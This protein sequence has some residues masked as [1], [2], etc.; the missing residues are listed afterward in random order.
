MWLYHGTYDMFYDKIKS[1]KKLNPYVNKDTFTIMLSQ[2]INSVAGRTLRGNC[3]YLS[4]DIEAM[5]GFDRYFR[6]STSKLDTKRLFV[7]DNSVL[8]NIIATVNTPESMQYI[9][10]YIQS[11][12][13]F[14]KYVK[15]KQQYNKMYTPEFLYFGVIKLA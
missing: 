10:K 6:I 3:V 2:S 8:D 5:D 7:G 12:M 15:I 1:E 11:Y 4:S 14:E 13:S 9:Q